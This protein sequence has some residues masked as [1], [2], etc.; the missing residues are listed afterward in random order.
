MTSLISKINHRL[1]AI[2]DPLRFPLLLAIR[3]YWGWQFFITGKGK[4]QNLSGVTEFFA[5]LRIPA[6]H[7]NA[8][9]VSATECFGGLFLL[10]GLGSR[11]FAGLFILEMVVAYGTSEH[12]AIRAIFSDSDQFVKATPFLFL[13]ASVIVFAFGPGRYSLDAL[14]SRKVTSAPRS[15]A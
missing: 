6:P 13:F 2:G 9:F 5:S 4:L 15:R 3:L 11:F 8:I 14:L 12:A 1:A 7:L 10:L